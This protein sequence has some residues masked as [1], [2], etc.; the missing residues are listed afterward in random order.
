MN[1]ALPIGSNEMLAADGLEHVAAK[2]TPPLGLTA[3]V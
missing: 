3:G 1:R 2:V